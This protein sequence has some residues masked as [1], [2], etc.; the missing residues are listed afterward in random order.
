[1]CVC[2]CVCVSHGLALWRSK[3]ERSTATV[4]TFLTVWV[5]TRQVATFAAASVEDLVRAWWYRIAVLSPFQ[6]KRQH[7]GEMPARVDHRRW[8]MWQAPKDFFKLSLNR[9]FGAPL[10]RLPAENSPHLMIL[11][12]W[13]SPILETCPAKSIWYFNCIASTFFYLRFF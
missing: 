5:D 11:S 3:R 12:R 4:G 2:V 8:L 13:W 6:K 1:M 10:S 9:F 7:G